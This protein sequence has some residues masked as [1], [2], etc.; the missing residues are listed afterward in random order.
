MKTNMSHVTETADSRVA[1]TERIMKLI[2]TLCWLVCLV[3]VLAGG[4]VA[5]ADA[6]NLDMTTTPTANG[7]TMAATTT[8][9]T[10]DITTNPG[11]LTMDIQGGTCLFNR[12]TT[13]GLGSGSKISFGATLTFET[14]TGYWNDRILQWNCQAGTNIYTAFMYPGHDGNSTYVGFG[15][16]ANDQ[17]IPTAI[18][19]GQPHTFRIDIDKATGMGSFY[20]DGTQLGSSK[21]VV[22]PGGSYTNFFFGDQDGNEQTGHNERW[23]NVFFTN[24]ATIPEPGMLGLLSLSA[25]WAISKRRK[26]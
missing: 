15:D 16:V 3:A 23:D 8:S 20:F 11:Q 7:F 19:I 2:R 18:T 1:T 17:N 10:Q 5:S 26:A 13:G 24:E 21:S 9:V 22:K 6:F 12:D 14:L 4:N 25:V